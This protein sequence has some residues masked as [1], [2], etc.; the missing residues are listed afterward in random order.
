MRALKW[1]AAAGLFVVCHAGA[2]DGRLPAMTEEDMA[3]CA[4]GG[5]CLI[6]TRE[7]LATIIERREKAALA[8]CRNWL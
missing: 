7:A 6:V 4:Q 5:G 3:M 8:A 2:D 1:L